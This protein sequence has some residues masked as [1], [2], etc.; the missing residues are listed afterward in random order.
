MAPFLQVL[1][2]GGAARLALQRGRV[3]LLIIQPRGWRRLQGRLARTAE[4]G[5]TTPRAAAGGR[6]GLEYNEII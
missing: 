4:S 2:R 6:R 5:A 3:A 1:R